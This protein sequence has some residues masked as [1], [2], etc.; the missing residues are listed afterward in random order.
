[1]SLLARISIAL[2]I[3]IAAI[4]VAYILSFYLL[5]MLDSNYHDGWAFS[6]AIFIALVAASAAFITSMRKT[7]RANNPRA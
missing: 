4:V 1:V 5:L 2:L 6:G 3:S 7:K